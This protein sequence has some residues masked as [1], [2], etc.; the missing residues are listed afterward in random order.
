MSVPPEVHRRLLS[1]FIEAV[2]S[3]NQ[4]ALMDLLAE[5][6]SPVADG[7][8]KIPG[9]ATQPVV[10][11]RAVAQ[12]AIGANLDFLPADYRVELSEVNYQP[13]LIARTADHVLVVLTIEVEQE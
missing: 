11:S 10:G 7:G 4:K 6:A 5:D 9:A 12:F 3:G 13:A 1:G 2:Q 8:G